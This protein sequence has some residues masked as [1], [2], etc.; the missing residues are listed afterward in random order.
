MIGRSGKRGSRAQGLDRSR[1]GFT[2]KLHA[3]CDRHGRPLGFVLTPGRA[4]DV[5]G[6]GPLFRMLDERID[7]L[8]A[9]KGYAANASPAVSSASPA[10]ERRLLCGAAIRFQIFERRILVDFCNSR[11]GGEDP[12]HEAAARHWCWW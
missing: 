1:G 9:D 2:T 10:K 8:L 7:E 4:H 3:R 6:F 12:K 11:V 5:K